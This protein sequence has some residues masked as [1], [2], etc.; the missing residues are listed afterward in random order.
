MYE[1][2]TLWKSGKGKTTLL[3]HLHG[4]VFCLLEV[5]KDALNTVVSESGKWKYTQEE[6]PE[7]LKDYEPLAG[8]HLS[9][10]APEKPAP[11][12]RKKK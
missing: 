12:T 5:G 7:R 1:N 9:V 2:G 6:L 10:E 8:G 11:K 4:G 3:Q